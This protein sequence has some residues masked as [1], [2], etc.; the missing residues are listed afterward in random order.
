[1]PRADVIYPTK[2]RK[3]SKSIINGKE[4]SACTPGSIHARS[5]TNGGR[6][7][8]K[9]DG[10]F[11]KTELSKTHGRMFCTQD[12]K[13]VHQKARIYAKYNH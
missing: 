13:L 6:F 9:A 1:M 11:A 10:I 3:D 8:P 2:A 12:M 5:K 4:M 7:A